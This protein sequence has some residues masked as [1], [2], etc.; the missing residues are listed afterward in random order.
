MSGGVRCERLP[1]SAGKQDG[2]GITHLP[3]RRAQVALER[4]RAREGLQARGL[5]DAYGAILARVTKPAIRE[6]GAL[7]RQNRSGGVHTHAP[8]DVRVTSMRVVA[9]QRQLGWP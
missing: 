3:R 9:A 2:D 7:R 4:E 5:A 8:V 6:A 1:N